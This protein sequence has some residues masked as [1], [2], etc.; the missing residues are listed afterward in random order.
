MELCG[1]KA[2]ELSEW[3]RLMVWAIYGDLHIQA[4]RKVK[5][6]ADFLITSE[7]NKNNVEKIFAESLYSS[8]YD[9][10]EMKYGYSN[11]LEL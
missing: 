3:H 4:K 10:G 2:E 5:E 7:T 6:N 11:D 8:E 9:Y 1:K